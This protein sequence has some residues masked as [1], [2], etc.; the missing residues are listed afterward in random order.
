MA[1]LFCTHCGFVIARG[2]FDDPE[3][4]L[5]GSP[6]A[7]C[8]GCGADQGIGWSPGDLSEQDIRAALNPQSGT[9][10][11]PDEGPRAAVERMMGEALFQM[12]AERAKK[13]LVRMGLVLLAVG[14]PAAFIS[15][16]FSPGWGWAVMVGLLAGMVAI[17]FI[18]KLAPS[19]FE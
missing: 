12:E 8:P 7:A 19:W 6:H 13:G 17:W 1:T 15:N 16:Y 3:Q 18:D 14:V 11:W 4:A 9:V 10:A 2:E 5:Q